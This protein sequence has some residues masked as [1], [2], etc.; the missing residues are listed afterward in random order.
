MRRGQGFRLVDSSP[1]DRADGEHVALEECDGEQAGDGVEGGGAADVDEGEDEGDETG[2]DH[3]VDGDVAGWVDLWV[4]MVLVFAG[5]LKGCR[6][7]TREIHSENGKPPSL[8]N[9]K[10]SRVTAVK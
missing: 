1:E 4:G 8:A 3:G 2:E 6:R 10:R 9:A 5:G 7:L